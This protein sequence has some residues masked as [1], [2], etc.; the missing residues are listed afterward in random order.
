MITPPVVPLDGPNAPG[1][2]GYFLL[3]NW[4]TGALVVLHFTIN[5]IVF[6]PLA[7]AFFAY[8]VPGALRERFRG[9]MA[10]AARAA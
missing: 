2:I 6:V 7:Y 1:L 8:D 3:T 5:L 4:G 9:A 10:P